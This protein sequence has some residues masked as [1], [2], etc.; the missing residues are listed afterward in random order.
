[1]RTN[2]DHLTGPP[3]VRRRTTVAAGLV[4]M[5]A[6]GAVATALPSGA[7]TAPAPTAM[8]GST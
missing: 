2:E 5:L 1:M 4:G 6:F 8:A 7:A 3:T